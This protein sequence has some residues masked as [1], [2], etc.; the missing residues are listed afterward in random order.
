MFKWQRNQACPVGTPCM[1]FSYFYPLLGFTLPTILISYGIAIPQ[2]CLAGINPPTVGL[3]IFIVAA[4]VTYWLGIHLV[5]RDLA[6]DSLNPSK[7]PVLRLRHLIP[8]FI[9]IFLAGL[10]A[11]GFIIPRS[12]IAGINEHSFGFGIALFFAAICYIEGVQRTLRK[13]LGHD[14]VDAIPVPLTLNHFYPLLIFLVTTVVIGYGAV[15]PKSCIAGWN[16]LTIGFGLALLGASIAYWQG[17]RMAL[18]ERK[19]MRKEH[20]EA[21]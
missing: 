3:G 17:V 2:S 15:I 11:Y 9:F 19:P 8:L 5:L 7:I 6:A 21:S 10:I 18:R 1:K 20:N 4:C 16:E 13:V 12:C 14:H